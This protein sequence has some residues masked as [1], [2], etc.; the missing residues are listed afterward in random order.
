ML[1]GTLK[2]HSLGS[3]SPIR[4]YSIVIVA[5][6]QANCLGAALRLTWTG[7]RCV[8][9]ALGCWPPAARVF[10]ATSTALCLALYDSSSS[11]WS[12]GLGGEQVAE[13][14]SRAGSPCCWP[15][16]C[17]SEGGY[18]VSRSQL[19]SAGVSWSQQESAG[20]SW[21][22]LESAGVSRSWPLLG[23]GVPELGAEDR[24]SN[25]A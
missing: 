7:T 1:N 3:L 11:S 13:A 4:T 19:E 6:R 18:V 25:P 21:S 14:S 12:C 17:L 24:Y 23:I 15:T 8:E 22:Q 10:W 2:K 9:E 5:V 16:T 20:V